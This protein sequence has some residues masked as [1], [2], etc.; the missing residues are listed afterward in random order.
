MTDDV[1]A[2]AACFQA[3]FGYDVDCHEVEDGDGVL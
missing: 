3:S 2:S 1:I